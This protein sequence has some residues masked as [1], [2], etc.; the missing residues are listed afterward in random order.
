MVVLKTLA[1]VV[2]LCLFT[3]L[4]WYSLNR[5]TGYSFQDVS[6]VNDLAVKSV[7]K[8]HMTQSEQNEAILYLYAEEK[9]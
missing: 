5:D 1:V 3:W 4:A 6:A 9:K 2:T 7:R 8:H